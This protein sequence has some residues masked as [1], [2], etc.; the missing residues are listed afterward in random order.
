MAPRL[1]SS[2]AAPSSGHVFQATFA[3]RLV[4]AATGDGYVAVYDVTNPRSVRLIK[5]KKIDTYAY[6]IVR[7]NGHVF[8]SHQNGLNVYDANDSTLTP[9]GSWSS[10]ASNPWIH[11][12]AANDSLVF[13][14]DHQGN[15]L[16]IL[17]WRALDKIKLLAPLNSIRDVKPTFSW[18]SVNGSAS[19]AF[20]L[21]DN[22]MYANPSM[23]LASSDTMIQSPVSLHSGKWWWKVTVTPGG[24]VVAGA[25]SVY[26]DTLPYLNAFAG[27]TLNESSPVFSWSPAKGYMG[28]YQLHLSVDTGFSTAMALSTPDTV[29]KFPA[30]LTKGKWFWKVTTTGGSSQLDSFFLEPKVNSGFQ[31]HARIS[32]MTLGQKVLRMATRE[33]VVV[34]DLG[35]RLVAKAW[36]ISGQV[37][38]DLANESAG[39]YLLRGANW[40]RTI[41]LP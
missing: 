6:R 8:I 21:A 23:S 41:L 34:Y 37:T 17:K 25:F 4:W 5:S 7:R 18:T 38:I 12:I 9:V 22:A 14:L 40:S 39:L 28:S 33:P 19:Y 30:S 1:L 31:E 15:G 3:G 27:D 32:V 13:A 2:G 36:P 35:G 16:S 11:G 26:A 20:V 10:I 29:L 24:Q